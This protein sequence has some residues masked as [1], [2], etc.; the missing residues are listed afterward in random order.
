MASDHHLAKEIKR[1]ITVIPFKNIPKCK[2]GACMF[3]RNHQKVVWI[4]Q[5]WQYFCLLAFVCCLFFLPLWDKDTEAFYALRECTGSTD[6]FQNSPNASSFFP[7]LFVFV[8]CEHLQT[9][10]KTV[11]SGFDQKMTLF[12]FVFSPFT[13][14]WKYAV[15]L[16]RGR[17]LRNVAVSCGPPPL[18]MY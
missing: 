5:G 12:V 2:K 15:P 10:S 7:S 8:T 9:L 16:W 18:F 3:Q 14:K 11:K 13:K 17:P 1:L 6:M 4:M